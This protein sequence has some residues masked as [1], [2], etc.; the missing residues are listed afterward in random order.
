MDLLP[1]ILKCTHRDLIP[2]DTSPGSIQLHY[3]KQIK[4]GYKGFSHITYA[5]TGEGTCTIWKK[6]NAPKGSTRKT[7]R[8]LLALLEA[9][10]GDGYFDV[11]RN[12]L[13]IFNRLNAETE[14]AFRA[15]ELEKCLKVLY[16]SEVML[17][18]KERVDGILKYWRRDVSTEL[19]ESAAE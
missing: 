7:N 8:T 15:S 9:W 12:G 16:S 19:E 2:N 18:D 1:F 4:D 14:I 3:T 5:S 10:I 17:L 13:E 11:Q 6:Q